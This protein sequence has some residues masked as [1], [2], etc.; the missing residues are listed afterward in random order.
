MKNLAVVLRGQLREWAACKDEIFK[1]FDLP[2]TN[3]VYFFVTWAGVNVDASYILNDFRDKNLGKLEIISDQVVK[4]LS[5]KKSS[6][7]FVEAYDRMTYIRQYA[8]MVVNEYELENDMVFDIVV[9]T[10][11]DLFITTN[12]LCVDF[13]FSDDYVDFVLGSGFIMKREKTLSVE[14]GFSG[15]I[16][17]ISDT[18]FV[19]DLIFSGNSLSMGV[20]NTE[21][22]QIQSET[23]HVFASSPHH[24]TAE[25]ILNSKLI[26]SNTAWKFFSQYDICRPGIRY[27]HS[28]L[29]IWKVKEYSDRYYEVAE[30]IE[31]L[32]IVIPLCDGRA[33]RKI[34]NSAVI[35]KVVESINL[36]IANFIFVCS[37]EHKNNET[38]KILESLCLPKFDVIY[39][40][41][42]LINDQVSAILQSANLLQ[43]DDSVTVVNSDQIFDYNSIDFMLNIF[44][45]DPDCQIL[46]FE[47]DNPS[48]SYSKVIGDRV[49][50]VAEKE[51]ISS[52]ANAGMY[53]FKKAKDMFSCIN[54]LIINA[55]TVNGK[56]YLSPAINY[57]IKSSKTVT[58]YSAKKVLQLGSEEEITEF[59]KNND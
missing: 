25:H 44:K 51:V 33:L 56:Y 3:V 49:L 34:G 29:D 36:P 48:W 31:K 22:E 58:N 17:R 5:A 19:D 14:L 6:T 28:E 26:I 37:K 41:G 43:P 1:S 12:T 55:N 50:L 47:G 7:K 15:E 38:K 27:Y 24:H 18:L 13:L 11:P 52:S 23:S 59:A 35:N 39:T 8:S 10:R 30:K 4:V 40:D 46:T 45:K 21:Y 2:D 42:R 54:S 57:L 32:S 53:Y 20:F 9:N 16:R